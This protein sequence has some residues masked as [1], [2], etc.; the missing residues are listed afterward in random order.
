MKKYIDEFLDV[1][2]VEGGV[3]VNTLQ[4]YRCDIEQFSEYINCKDVMKVTESQ[5]EEYLSFLYQEGCK[6]KTISRKI[7]CIREFFKF[8]IGEKYINYNPST[9][10]KNPK[11]GKS[12][13]SFLTPQEIEDICNAALLESSYSMRRMAVMIK[14]MYTSGLRVSELVCLPENAINYTMRQ[15][16]ILGKG[17]KE[18]VVPISNDV[19]KE[20]MDYLQYRDEF[21]GPKGSPWLFPSLKSLSGHITRDGFFKSLKKIAIKAGISPAKIHPHILRHTF[22]TH[23]VNNNADLRSIQ[24]MLGHE[25]IVTTEIYT[26]ITTTKLAQE[27]KSKHP[28]ANKMRS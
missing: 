1:K 10:I 9:K 25:N 24:K 20:L 7:S 28:L 11:I 26:H 19:V 15:I 3:S 2:S 23:L 12:L 18:R 27:V 22:A 6:P 8:L 14:L 4:A 17:S 13:P 21:V 5:I 16:L